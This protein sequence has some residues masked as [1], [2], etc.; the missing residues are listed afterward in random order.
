MATNRLVFEA[1]ALK[2]FGRTIGMTLAL[3]LILPAPTVFLRFLSWYYSCQRFADGTRVTSELNM[4][5]IQG[6]L[7]MIGLLFWVSIGSQFAVNGPLMKQAAQI[8]CSVVSAYFSFQVMRMV[9]DTTRTNSGSLLRFAGTWPQFLRWQAGFLALGALPALS[10]AIALEPAGLRLAVTLIA[11][12]ATLTGIALLIVPYLR[13]ITAMVQGG[14]RGVTFH[15]ST[16]SLVLRYLA[17]G[18]GSLLIF[19]IPWT[20]LSFMKWLCRQYELPL[21]T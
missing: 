12:L 9:V 17:F 4:A 19:T 20:L 18:L 10:E 14:S 2:F 1:E 8:L 11:S 16:G 6:P 15:A 21:R 7:R 3:F 5:Q 13:W